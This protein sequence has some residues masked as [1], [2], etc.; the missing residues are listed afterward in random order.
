MAENTTVKKISDE[1]FIH[2]QDLWKIAI[3]KWHYFVFSI[4]I[5]L[6]VAVFYI[7]RTTPLYT[8]SA[9]LLI[10]D[11]SKK[12]IGAGNGE[13]SNLD[14]FKS[15]AN[16][17][18]EILTLQSP[19]LM[20]EV[21]RALNLNV[22]YSVSEGLRYKTLYDQSPITVKL[23]DLDERESFS[24]SI[25]LLNDKVQLSDFVSKGEKMNVAEVT[26]TL[27]KPLATPFGSV[28]ISSTSHHVEKNKKMEIFFSKVDIKSVANSYVHALSVTLGNEEASIVNLT[29]KDPSVKRG[30]DIL[31][32]LINVYNENWIEDKNKMAISTSDFIDKRLVVI[33]DELGNVD[34]NI[35]EFKSKNLLPDIQSVTSMYM[36][37]SNDNNTRLLALNNQL[38]VMKYVKR[39]ISDPSSKNQLIPSGLGI[40]DM[41]IQTLVNEYNTMMLKR[42]TLL[43]NSS[44]N[45][46]LLKD[47]NESLNTIRQSVISSIN[48][49][50]KT[51]DLQTD[52]I[53]KSETQT[54]RQIATNPS[55][56]K[57]LLSVERQQKVKESLY[58]Y[59]LQKREENQLS[60]AF[61]AYNTRII[62]PP[63]GNTI[64]V[65]PQKK[66]IFLIALAV[67]LITPLMII[68][69]LNNLDISVRNR[70]DL[71][72]VTVPFI[73]EIPSNLDVKKGNF[74]NRL[75]HSQKHKSDNQLSIVVGED[76]HNYINEAFRVVRTNLDF[77]KGKSD[78]MK[79]M[80]MT[81]F[82]PDSGKT[83]IINN[84]AMSQALA[85]KKVIVINL[86]MR[87]SGKN[88]ANL[89][90]N[91]AGISNY[92]N[93]FI[94]DPQD[95]IEKGSLH[96]NL[97]IIPIG[98]IPPNPTELLLSER[99]PKLFNYLRT[100]YDYILVDCT[101]ID[102]VADPVIIEKHA[103]LTIFVIRVGLLDRRMLPELEEMYQN[104]R[105]KNMV[106]LLNGVI[107]PYNKYGYYYGSYHRK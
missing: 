48:N 61:T 6:S 98:S 94:D 20:A 91:Q 46:P 106:M 3:K 36:A 11:D 5:C 10:K 62:N 7:A 70:K 22:N 84:L 33:E 56:A 4:I 42:N 59:L 40:A 47:I 17:N 78:K 45:N 76:V 105:F 49:I 51:T 52:N 53:I 86:D 79:V 57:Y 71:K 99:L 85:G 21:V 27:S 60:Q 43:S 68:F 90:V 69:L 66:T 101:P 9:S 41:D 50:V 29:I 63:S 83:F 77:M 30:E 96:P 102:L 24:F 64:P 18:N 44:D 54:N 95:I 93:G 100:I 89:D 87:T 80:L 1:S 65:F 58:L 12:N 14:L 92:L 107:H 8:C 72:D 37:Q 31:N 13:F 82:N 32:T 75:F 88:L 55:Q 97:D 19:A 16:I 67:G 25:Q 104:K 74:Y 38:T 35:S 73:G 34:N 15:T 23:P 103:D 81:S 28:I 26:G 2:L 39:Y